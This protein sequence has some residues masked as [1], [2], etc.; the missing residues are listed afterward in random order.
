M[1]GLLP[2]VAKSFGCQFAKI[3]FYSHLP[4]MEGKK[5]LKTGRCNEKRYE[6]TMRIM[7]APC[8]SASFP[9]SFAS[10]IFA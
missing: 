2:L 10:P 3:I 8:K 7:K 4:A 5:P 9:G 1:V 6:G